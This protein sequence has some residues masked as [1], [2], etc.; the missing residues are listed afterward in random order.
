M[1]QRRLPVLLP[2]PPRSTL[3]RNELRLPPLT[4]RT[5]IA[6]LKKAIT[7]AYP[8]KNHLFRKHIHL[9][10]THSVRVFTCCTLVAADLTDAQ[11]EH[12]LRWCSDAWKTYVRDSFTAVDKTSILLFKEAHESN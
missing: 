11:I 12:K 2:I 5:V 9:F 3:C 7:F 10:T 8:D 6:V 1:N 4:D